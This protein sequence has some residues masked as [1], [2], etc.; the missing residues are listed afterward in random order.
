M[1]TGLFGSY[2]PLSDFREVRRLAPGSMKASGLI[3]ICEALSMPDAKVA[4][5]FFFGRWDSDMAVMIISEV[6]SIGFDAVLRSNETVNRLAGPR[7]D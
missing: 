5:V 2:R 1:S 3:P 6:V 4:P 7:D